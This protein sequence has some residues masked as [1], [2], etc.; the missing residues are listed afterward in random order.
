MAPVA[1]HGPA[2]L[3]ATTRGFGRLL[4]GCFNTYWGLNKLWCMFQRRNTVVWSESTCTSFTMSLYTDRASAH[5]ANLGMGFAGRGL[6]NLLEESRIIGCINTSACE[7]TSKNQ[8]HTNA[9]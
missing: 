4:A 8:T 3:C 6:Y 9:A 1:L 5:G 7:A 2:D